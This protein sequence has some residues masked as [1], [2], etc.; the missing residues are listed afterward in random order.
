[1]PLAKGVEGGVSWMKAA[2]SA[3][4]SNGLL[5]SPGVEARPLPFVFTLRLASTS[6]LCFQRGRAAKII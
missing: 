2:L 1:M 3:V 4:I 5:C 6:Q